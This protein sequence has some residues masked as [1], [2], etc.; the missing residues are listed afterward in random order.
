MVGEVSIKSPARPAWPSSGLYARVKRDSARQEQKKDTEVWTKKG[1][2]RIYVWT[3]RPCWTKVV[4]RGLAVELEFFSG[5]DKPWTSLDVFGGCTGSRDNFTPSVHQM[6]WAQQQ[7]RI[8]TRTQLRTLVHF[9]IGLDG[10]VHCY[11]INIA[12]NNNSAQHANIN[13]LLV[14]KIHQT[15]SVAVGAFI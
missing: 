5:T 8:L 13:I 3:E 6:H 15:W 1:S 2:E 12:D 9:I 10:L 7:I 11:I 14:C 4:Q